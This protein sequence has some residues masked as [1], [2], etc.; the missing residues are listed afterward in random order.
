LEGKGHAT[1]SRMVLFCCYM[2]FVIILKL[3]VYVHQFAGHKSNEKYGLNVYWQ[4]SV[5]SIFL[6]SGQAYIMRT[7][8]SAVL[9][10]ILTSNIEEYQAFCSY[11]GCTSMT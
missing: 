9:F 4:L 11:F 5:T 10:K 2:V 8:S 6:V 1:V 3:F 7:V